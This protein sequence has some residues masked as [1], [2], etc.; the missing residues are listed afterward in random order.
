[1]KGI[2]ETRRVVWIWFLHFY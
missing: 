2:P 1:M